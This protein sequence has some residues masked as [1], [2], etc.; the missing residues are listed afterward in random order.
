ML[1]DI[2][3]LKG[4]T[5]MD[6]AK[7]LRFSKAISYLFHP[8]LFPLLATLFYLFSSPRFTSKR[9]KIVLVLVVFFGTYLLPIMLLAF[10]KKLEMIQS[11]QLQSIDERKFPVLFF[12]FLAILV[13]RLFFQIQVVDN[14]ALFFIAGGIS[15]LV[16]YSLLWFQF[17]VSI[18]TL[19]IGGFI[20]FLINLSLVYHHNHLFSIAFLFLLFGVVAKARLKLK[21][22][23]FSEVLWGLVLGVFSQ[24]LIPV[25]FQNI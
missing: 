4:K 12:S 6:A 20:G 14:L 2:N 13:G 15:F 24:L 18:H 11:F 17:K 10:F 8:I 21:A 3:S 7:N 23:T 16:L 22:H 9:T 25:L 1:Q 5:E 19:S